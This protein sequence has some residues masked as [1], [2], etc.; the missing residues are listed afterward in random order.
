MRDSTGFIHRC[1]PR[2]ARALGDHAKE[3]LADHY[4]YK[5]DDFEM[6]RGTTFLGLRLPS[7]TTIAAGM[8]LFVLFT[9]LK[10]KLG[11]NRDLEGLMGVYIWDEQGRREMNE[12]IERRSGPLYRARLAATR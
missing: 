1:W 9:G 8:R 11:H 10:D 12:I 2:Q 7:L 5:L 3:F 6:Q 4:G